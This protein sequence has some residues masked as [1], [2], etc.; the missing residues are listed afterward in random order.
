MGWW[1]RSLYDTCSLITLDKSFLERATLSRHFPKG[2]LALEKSFS[3]DQLRP[4]TARRMRRRVTLQQLPPTA[5]LAAVLESVM[6]SSALAEVDKLIYATAVH[7]NLSVVTGDRRLGRALRDAGLQVMDIASIL[8][9][10]VHSKKLSQ[11]GCER[12]LVG[13]AR[14]NDLLLGVPSPTWKDLTDHKFPDR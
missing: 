4:A 12:L 10:L 11:A 6:L 7:F 2:I 3:V 13:L 14:R 8:R 5:E 1:K 9:D